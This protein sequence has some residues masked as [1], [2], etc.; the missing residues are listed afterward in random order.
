MALSRQG[1][2]RSTTLRAFD[3]GEMKAVVGQLR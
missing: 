1:F 3:E 2:V